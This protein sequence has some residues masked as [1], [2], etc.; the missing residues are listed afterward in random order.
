MHN[1]IQKPSIQA[2]VMVKMQRLLGKDILRV[3]WI[4]G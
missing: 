4:T 1:D 3:E 2:N